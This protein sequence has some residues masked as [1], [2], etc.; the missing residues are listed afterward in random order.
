MHLSTTIDFDVAKSFTNNNGIVLFSWKIKNKQNINKYR[1]SSLFNDL[2]HY[3][4]LPF[5]NEKEYTDFKGL[6]PH[7]IYGF[8]IIREN[9]NI[10]VVNHHLFSR[11]NKNI[12]KTI[13]QGIFIDQS[14]FDKILEETNYKK[15]FVG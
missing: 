8:Q 3:N 9:K 12:K 14:N 13:Q 10:F 15:F 5:E 6:F 2:P 11:F 4:S 1:V 7:Y